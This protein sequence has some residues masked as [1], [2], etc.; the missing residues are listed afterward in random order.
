MQVF[1]SLEG[2]VFITYIIDL[3]TDSIDISSEQA[4]INQANILVPRIKNSI[5]DLPI[6]EELGSGCCCCSCFGLS[7]NTKLKKKIKL[8]VTVN[9]K[10]FFKLWQYRGKNS[11]SSRNRF[12]S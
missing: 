8:E 2:R 9:P 5:V 12:A 1:I 11:D 7:R 4:S 3:Y 6:E 10:A